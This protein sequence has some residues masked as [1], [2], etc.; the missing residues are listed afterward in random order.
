MRRLFLGVSLLVFSGLFGAV[1]W[2]DHI[3]TITTNGGATVKQ[4]SSEELQAFE[5]VTVRTENEFVDGMRTFQGPLVRDILTACGAADA[6]SVVLTAANDYQVTVDAREFARYNAILATSMDGE[7]LSRRD[8]GPIW[9]IYP[10]SD[11]AELRDPV[12]NSR[13]IWQL[14]KLDAR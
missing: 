6:R 1:A 8:K 14:V 13:L 11:H 4:L 2:A 9:V 10:M 3:L 7:A 5:Q 12:Y